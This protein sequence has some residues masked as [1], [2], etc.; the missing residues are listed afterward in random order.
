V[1]AFIDE[2]TREI[3]ASPERVW[4]ALVATVGELFAGLPG[5]LADAWGLEPPARTGAWDAAAAVG[6]TVPGFTVAELK[7]ARVL[8]LRGRHRFSDYELRF[9]LERRSEDRTELR[10]ISSADFPGITGRLYRL[11]VIGTGGHRVAVRR[12]LGTVARRAEGPR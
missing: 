2:H 11:L 5:W 6:D 3:D 4:S 8:A 1:R 7:P 10:A 9:E 12:M